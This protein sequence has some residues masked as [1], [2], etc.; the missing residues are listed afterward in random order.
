MPSPDWEQLYREKSLDLI[1]CRIRCSLYREGVEKTL[2][3]L[4]KWGYS[5]HES[6]KSQHLAEDG[7]WKRIENKR[8]SQ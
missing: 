4:K 8:L 3:H 5:P 6:L 2:Y 7:V 1:R